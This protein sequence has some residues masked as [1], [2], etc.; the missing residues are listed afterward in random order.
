[1]RLALLQGGPRHGAPLLGRVA[2]LGRVF[3][4]AVEPPRRLPQ[5]LSA[6]GQLPG[7]LVVPA[8]VDPRTRGG[9]VFEV[10]GCRGYILAAAARSVPPKEQVA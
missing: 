5:V 8:G 4:V 3:Y 2:R 1:M 6:P 10:A 9:V 7:V